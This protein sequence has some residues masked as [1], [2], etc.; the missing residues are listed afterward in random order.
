MRHIVIVGASLAGVHAAEGLREAGFAGRITLVGAEAQLPYDRPAL[1]K[2]ALREGPYES[3]DFVRLH[4]AEWYTDNAVELQLGRK[5]VALRPGS[6]TLLLAD[7]TSTT[8]D[9]LVLATGSAARE[10]RG[11][12]GPAEVMRLRT[13][14]DC[15]RLHE[16]LVPGQH[17]VVI[18]AGFIGLEVAA[19]AR[20]VGMD[21][22]VVEVAPAPLARVLGDEVG[23]WFRDYHAQHG[24]DIHCGSAVA[25]FE[26]VGNVTKVHLQDGTVLAADVIVAGVGSMPAVAWLRD[27]GLNMTDG[28]ICDDHLRT[29]APDVVAAGDIAR[30]YNPLFDETLRIEQW[31][32]AVEQ[33]RYAARALLGLADGPYAD[34]PYFWSDQFDARMR[35]VG[36]ASAASHVHIE[37]SD[38]HR[39]IALFGR[40]DVV[41]GVLC[42]NAPRQLGSYRS[43]IVD[44]TRWSD[45][46]PASS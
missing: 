23:G 35:F 43:A 19:T 44:R 8:Y 36:R 22:A 32:N 26:A 45:I 2:G 46:V 17:L 37:Q 29:S 9:G 13:A 38:E 40:D 7:G 41:C 30:W 3:T 10:L 15:A 11:V 16:R 12:E 34:A 18:G 42:V 20:Q 39:L 27:S 25:A 14:E 6:R 33:G 21:V 28:V 24:V 31:T 4:P 5:A 1:S